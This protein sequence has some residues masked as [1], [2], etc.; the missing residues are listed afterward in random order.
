MRLGHH[1][2]HA[3]ACPPENG[4]RHAHAT[5]RAPLAGAVAATRQHPI[6]PPQ[7]RPR[8]AP[9]NG[10]ACIRM[11]WQCRS[12]HPRGQQ[13]PTAPVTNKPFLVQRVRSLTLPFAWRR[14]APQTPRKTR[15]LAPLVTRVAVACCVLH[16]LVPTGRRGKQSGPTRLALVASSMLPLE[17]TRCASGA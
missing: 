6:C 10:H 3:F 17:K 12:W 15:I 5:H 16:V 4:L 11:A 9:A 7:R 13:W 14:W 1:H 2:R 8:N